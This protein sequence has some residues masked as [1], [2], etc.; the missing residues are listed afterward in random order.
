MIHQLHLLKYHRVSHI[1]LNGS[2]PVDSISFDSSCDLDLKTTISTCNY[3]TFA[4]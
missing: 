4:E 1:D 3:L 2:C